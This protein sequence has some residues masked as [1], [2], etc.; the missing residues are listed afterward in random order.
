LT[1][2]VVDDHPDTREIGAGARVTRSRSLIRV[3]CFVF[4]WSSTIFAV[5]RRLPPLSGRV[6]TTASTL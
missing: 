5:S 4:S 6:V 3:D 2:L 1:I